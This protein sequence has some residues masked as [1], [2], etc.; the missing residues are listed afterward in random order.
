MIPAEG[1]AHVSKEGT[2]EVPS[3]SPTEQGAMVNA[4]VVNYSLMVMR[5]ATFDDIKEAYLRKLAM[6]GHRIRK[7]RIEVVG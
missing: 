4:L 3:I 7:V 5:D 1:Y 2:I 6:S